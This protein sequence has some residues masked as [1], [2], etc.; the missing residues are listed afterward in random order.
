M[1]TFY[2][3]DEWDDWLWPLEMVENNINNNIYESVKTERAGQIAIERRR[4]RWNEKRAYINAKAFISSFLIWSHLTYIDQCNRSSRCNDSDDNRMAT[5]WWMR[6]CLV[7]ALTA[8]LVKPSW[9]QKKKWNEMREAQRRSTNRSSSLTLCTF[10]CECQSNGK[11]VA[12]WRECRQLQKQ[13]LCFEQ[14]NNH[15]GN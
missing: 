3:M 7:F 14:V 10:E 13:Y 8:N 12:V 9:K 2:G 11:T 5:K 1:N 4:K 15:L 6:L